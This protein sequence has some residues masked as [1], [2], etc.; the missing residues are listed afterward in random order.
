MG[1]E[2]CLWLINRLQEKTPPKKTPHGIENHKPHTGNHK[3]AKNNVELEVSGHPLKIGRIHIGNS[4]SFRTL[5]KCRFLLHILRFRPLHFQGVF[6]GDV[7]FALAE[8][9]M[10]TK[11]TSSNIWN[12]TGVDSLNDVKWFQNNKGRLGF[13]L[14][15]RGN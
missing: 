6:V 13:Y 15:A 11:M 3:S 5:E 14:M 10:C 12:P 4:W 7:F 8:L 2:I 1:A 9:I